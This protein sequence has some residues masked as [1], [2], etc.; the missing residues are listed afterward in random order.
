M[1]KIDRVGIGEQISLTPV[2]VTMRD[3]EIKTNK[4][5]DHK[6]IVNLHPNGGTHW[7]LGIL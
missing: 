4:N 2:V 1:S 7:V 3:E 6:I 5:I